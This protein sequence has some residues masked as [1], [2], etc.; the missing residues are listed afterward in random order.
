MVLE[1]AGLSSQSRT[2]VRTAEDR[3]REAWQPWRVLGLHHCPCKEAF[4]AVFPKNSQPTT[5]R[6][7]GISYMTCAAFGNPRVSC[8][9]CSRSLYPRGNP[10]VLVTAVV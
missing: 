10:P 8:K 5:E 7:V 3:T 4:S 1:A 6:T 2:G 9:T